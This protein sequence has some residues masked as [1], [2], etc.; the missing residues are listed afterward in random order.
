MRFR[1]KALPVA[2]EV[3]VNWI[4][5]G[6]TTWTS[7]WVRPLR[8][9]ATSFAG[10]GHEVWGIDSPLSPWCCVRS[11]IGC[12]AFG[13]G[14]DIRRRRRWRGPSACVAGPGPG[15]GCGRTGYG[16]FMDAAQL[17]PPA[18]NR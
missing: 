18:Q 8:M 1:R 4:K 3:F 13:L 12:L 15:E 9:H 6:E 17:S 11:L 14:S 7:S 10:E 16:F 2:S 5:S